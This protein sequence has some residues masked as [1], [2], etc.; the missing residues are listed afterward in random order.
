MKIDDVPQDRGMISDDRREIC[1][2]V[3]ED[4]LYVLAQSAGWE[5]KN[6]AND[7][8]WDIIRQQVDDTLKKIEAGELSPLA[9]HMVKNQMN[10]SLL[11]KYVRIN[12]WRV[13]RHLKPEVYTRLKPSVLKKYADV[14]EI[15]VEQLSEIP[16][17]N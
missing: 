13:K 11:A 10:V 7:Q 12:R 14:F 16:K 8:A 17:A 6:I 3:D 4:D 1:Y 9:F 15:S 2:A 5:V